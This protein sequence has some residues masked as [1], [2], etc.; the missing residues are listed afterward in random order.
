MS[1]KVITNFPDIHQFSYN[2]S[3]WNRQFLEENVILN[4][5]FS[6]LYYPAHWTTLSFKFAFGGYEY[7]IMDKMKYGVDNSSFL[8]LN[9]DTIYES[10]ID[11]ADT[12]ETLTLNFTEK[13]IND[14]YHSCFNN[15][16]YLLDY[17]EVRDKHPVNFFQKLYPADDIVAA[18]T[19]RM[20]KNI[21]EGNTCCLNELMHLLMEYVFK[22]QLK[23]SIEAD[24]IT[25]K[26]RSTRYELFNRLNTAKDYISSNYNTKIELND[27]GK[28][29]TLSPHHLLRKFK[30]AFGITPHNYLTKI[31]I[32]KAEEFLRQSE[33]SVT[34]ICQ[35]V[36]FESL[37]SFGILFKR[38]TG[39][40]PDKYRLKHRKKVNF[41]TIK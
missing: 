29:S 12:V 9:R 26:K 2:Y 37:S 25:S 11:S 13:F 41:G 27:L 6:Y 22:K 19:G 5:K 40:P 3:S 33:K 30:S 39:Y 36:G 4:G 31:R 28:I 34:E 24:K 23:A 20:R 18:I 7:Y 17:P 16:E 15:E 35:E 10:L 32:K 38:K 21:S 14:V 1:I 8:I